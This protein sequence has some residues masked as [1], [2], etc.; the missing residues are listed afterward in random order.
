VLCL[1]KK[2]QTYQIHIAYVLIT[3]A[4][5]DYSLMVTPQSPLL[6][7]ELAAIQRLV[8]GNRSDAPTRLSLYVLI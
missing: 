6:L 8:A 2:P 4:E 7:E 5:I 1:K 3:L